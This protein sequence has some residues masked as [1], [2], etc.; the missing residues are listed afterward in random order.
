MGRN[1]SNLLNMTC[2]N[3]VLLR[4]RYLNRH[5]SKHTPEKSFKWDLPGIGIA[6]KGDV[7]NHQSTPTGKK[8]YKYDLC[9]S[10][11]SLNRGLKSHMRAYTGRNLSNVTCANYALL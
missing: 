5:L 8:R 11:F 2:V 4:K 9:E 10:C 6:Q 1:H 7:N 3:Q